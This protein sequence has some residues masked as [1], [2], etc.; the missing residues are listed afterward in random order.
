MAFRLKGTCF[1]I[2]W[3]QLPLTEN[4][5]DAANLLQS[6]L[7]LLHLYGDTSFV[8]AGIERH[9]D[10]GYHCHCYCQY[11][12]G[13]DR[14]LSNQW[15]LLGQHPNVRSKR[16]RRER[17]AA[18][19]YTAK[20]GVFAESGEL[21]PV[22]VDSDASTI[23]DLATE[24]ANHATYQSWLQYCL[25]NS[26]PFGYATE[27]W[28]TSRAGAETLEDPFVVEGEIHDPILL[29]M[30]FYLESDRALV[31]VGGSG[32]G[33]TTWARREIPKP[34]LFVRHIDDLRHFRSGFHVGIV[35]DDMH[36]AGDHQ[37]KGAWPRTSQIHLLDFHVGSSIHCRYLT[38]YIPA[39]IHKIFVGNSFMFNTADDAIRRR[40]TLIEL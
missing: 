17:T 18:I 29:G 8:R 5:Q 28:K 4:L 2:T 15:D 23:P 6:I 35:F 39:G 32:I 1:L 25:T 24:I 31:I 40:I 33:K 37:G 14:R 30:R 19:A 16:T 7:P 9:Q 11:A 27:F 22:G 12:R 20:D 36:F 38:C 10:G 34:A 3:S 26:I 21:E 13:I